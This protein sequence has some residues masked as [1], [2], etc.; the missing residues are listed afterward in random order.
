MVVFLQLKQILLRLY[1][2]KKRSNIID[3]EKTSLKLLDIIVI[4]KTTTSEIISS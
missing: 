3:L 1:R 2:A 4:K